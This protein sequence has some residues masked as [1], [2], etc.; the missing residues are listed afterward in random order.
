M[1]IQH[2]IPRLWVLDFE[3]KPSE[4]KAAAST[5]RRL[6]SVHAEGLNVG[7]KVEILVRNEEGTSKTSLL[8]SPGH[9]EQVQCLWRCGGV[10][11]WYDCG[12]IPV[13]V[14]LQNTREE[15]SRRTV[16]KDG[17]KDY[18]ASIS[19]ISYTRFFLLVADFL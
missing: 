9:G 3:A 11:L 6:V 2:Y 8:Q 12:W 17:W 19:D 13:L 14:E 5:C 10:L 18:K 15:T 1:H 4:R 16:K 7:Q